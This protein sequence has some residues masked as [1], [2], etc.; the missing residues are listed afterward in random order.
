MRLASVPWPCAAHGRRA[1]RRGN[2]GIRGQV[3]CICTLYCHLFGAWYEA[4]EH[5]KYTSAYLPNLSNALLSVAQVVGSVWGPVGAAQG[6]C[7]IRKKIRKKIRI[8]GVHRYES[9]LPLPGTPV[10]SQNSNPKMFRAV[11]LLLLLSAPRVAAQAS[12]GCT[13]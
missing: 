1:G 12:T 9:C 13:R 8:L 10:T 2:Q 6:M 4:L 7:E 3:F 11:A 5:T